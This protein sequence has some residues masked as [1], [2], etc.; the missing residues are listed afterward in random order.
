MMNCCPR[1]YST[2][3]RKRQKNPDPLLWENSDIRFNMTVF[4]LVLNGFTIL[5]IVWDYFLFNCSVA[6]MP[7]VYFNGKKITN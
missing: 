4:K 2:F 7:T 1:K 5:A 6:R 3:Q